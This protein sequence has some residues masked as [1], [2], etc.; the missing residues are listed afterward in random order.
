MGNFR[1]G[2]SPIFPIYGENESKKEV[3]DELITR[4]IK[5]VKGL[6]EQDKKFHAFLLFCLLINQEIYSVHKNEI[7]SI[8]ETFL[9]FSTG[10]IKTEEYELLYHFIQT[11]NQ[12]GIKDDDIELVKKVD[13][14]IGSAIEN[15]IK[16]DKENWLKN[17]IETGSDSVIYL[18]EAEGKLDRAFRLLNILIDSNNFG[19]TIRIFD[20][21]EEIIIKKRE[22]IDDIKIKEFIKLI[23]KVSTHLFL[24]QQEKIA[25]ELYQKLKN[26]ILNVLKYKDLD[27]ITLLKDAWLIES[28]IGYS[29]NENF[30]AYLLYN[31][32]LDQDAYFSEILYKIFMKVTDNVYHID[33]A[34]L[35][36]I[37][38]KPREL[39][40]EASRI[41]F[42]LNKLKNQ[43]KISLRLSQKTKFQAPI[44]IL[45]NTYIDQNTRNILLQ[46]FKVIHFFPFAGVD[47][48]SCDTLIQDEEFLGWKV[49]AYGAPPDV[50]QI[51]GYPA[52]EIGCDL[53]YFLGRTLF[54]L[55]PSTIREVFLHLQ[56]DMQNTVYLQLQIDDIEIPWDFFHDGK[57]FLINALATGNI[58]MEPTE[59]KMIKPIEFGRDKINVLLIGNPTGD[60]EY[61]ID[62]VKKICEGLK[63]IFIVNE[64]KLILRNEASKENILEHIK[65]GKYQIIHYAG[66]TLFN[67]KMPAYS[68]LVLAGDQ[69][70][71]SHELEDALE[72]TNNKLS[73]HPFIYLNSCDASKIKAVES[74][75]GTTKFDGISISLI[76]GGALGC[77]GNHWE[78]EDEAIRDF[79][80]TFYKLLLAGTPVGEAMLKARNKIYPTRMNTFECSETKKITFENRS[81]G[82]PKLFGEVQISL[83]EKQD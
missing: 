18:S 83:I 7:Y 16:I 79:S 48:E 42:T 72:F 26:L 68:G 61:T 37:E 59:Y 12:I 28:I 27:V 35:Y 54:L 70:L 81:W 67:E 66:H 23:L 47:K 63:D 32:I 31:A 10:L 21:I 9:W 58:V 51:M 40:I 19:Q 57:N 56:N 17:Y 43:Y 8:I 46:I 69:L 2:I 5:R 33:K 34:V 4:Q 80:I 38:K 55:L 52:A 50:D 22:N 78:V 6:V 82:S 73:Y 13:H 44:R 25:E 36:S 11:L 65:S 24:S 20:K 64:T 41:E 39:S 45:D 77:I 29:H 60:L 14:I 62:E 49:E 15:L 71:T 53:L 76:R 75:D 74:K 3:Y 1:E 30:W